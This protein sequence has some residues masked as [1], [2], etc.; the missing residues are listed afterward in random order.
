MIGFGLN[1]SNRVMGGVDA[2]A[3]A[4][5]NRVIADGGVVPAGVS[6]VNAFFNA[7]KSIYG[8][9]DITT[10]ISV[11]VDAHYLGYKMGAGS[12]ATLGQAVQKLYSCAGS[13]GDVVQTTATSQPL[14]LAHNG[15]STDNYW[16]S[17][18]VSANWCR[19]SSISIPTSS[20]MSVEAKV[21]F[22]LNDDLNNGIN[23]II[24]LDNGGGLRHFIF[25]F[26]GERVL[27]FD[28]AALGR[29]AVATAQIPEAFSGWVKVELI[30]SGAD[31]LVK[32]YTSLD[33]I[34]Y[35]QLGA[36]ITNLLGANSIPTTSTFLNCNGGAGGGVPISGKT[37]RAILKDAN[38]VTRADFNP[39]TYNASTS[40]TQW[41]STTGEVWTINTGT[42]TT[43]YKGALV[44]RTIV[45]SDGVDDRM[46]SGTLSSKQYFT[47][48]SSARIFS[49]LTSEKPIYSSATNSH[50][51]Y[52]VGSI[53]AFNGINLISGNTSILLNAQTVDFNDTSS[54]I[55]INAGADTLGSTGILTSTDCK[56]FVYAG[57]VFGNVIFN[58]L[59]QPKSL[60]SNTTKTAMYNYI[61]S[62]N[63]NAF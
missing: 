17:S 62:I 42:A 58:T 39:A 61:R 7:V 55:R 45:Q 2:Q 56:L 11:G 44:D 52:G 14:L 28:W 32:F 54:K 36:T 4:H 25:G 38:G 47:S 20:G 49:Y 40:Q 50:M 9:S 13:S 3:Q 19:A 18:G 27:S 6:G 10:A 51:L 48:Y 53:F 16:Y 26:N 23:R 30:T 46:A 33:G 43:G 1:I 5:Y 31:M 37:Y 8:T 59:I 60:D 24:S 12:G 29:N 15:A 22:T 34:T 41:T 63:N 35:T 21:S 57:V